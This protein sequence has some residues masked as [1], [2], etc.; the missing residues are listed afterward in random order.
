[1]N[2]DEVK[3]IREAF[4]FKVNRHMGLQEFGEALGFEP[5]NAQRAM[6]RWESNDGPSG[7]GAI[8]LGYM[9]Q[10]LR[11]EVDGVPKF[12]TEKIGGRV[13]V[14][15]TH[16]PRFILIA[17]ADITSEMI[18]IDQ[19]DQFGEPGILATWTEAR[20]IATHKFD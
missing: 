20:N 13:F 14:V 12:I 16:W 6:R 10:G 15:H 18:W 9:G 5:A 17:N 2:G 8:A 3:Q 7:P 11:A 4:G 1:M 19:P